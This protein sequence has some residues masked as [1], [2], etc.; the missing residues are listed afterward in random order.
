MGD[1]KLHGEAPDAGSTPNLQPPEAGI[2]LSASS[3][4]AGNAQNRAAQNSAW[5]G[6]HPHADRAL[7]CADAVRID[8]AW[9]VTGTDEEEILGYMRAH[10]R[11][12]HGKNEFT[13]TELAAVRR[14][15]HKLAA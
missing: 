15:I 8:C 7:R 13:S 2:D 11:E 3:T 5:P 1:K 4:S 12:V 6:A 14:A 9:S 10:A